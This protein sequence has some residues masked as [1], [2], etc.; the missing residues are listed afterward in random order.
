M[1]EK[2]FKYFILNVLPHPVGLILVFGI[3]VDI[4]VALVVVP[5]RA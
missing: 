3:N 5:G 4:T 2:T 1:R